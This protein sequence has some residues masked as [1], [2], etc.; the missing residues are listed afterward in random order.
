VIRH[1]AAFGTIQ[2][3]S[4]A[5]KALIDHRQQQVASDMSN[6]SLQPLPTPEA[7]D[8]ATI[9][10]L[11]ARWEQA[12]NSHDAASLAGLVDDDID[13]VTVSGRWL[14]GRREFYDWHRFIHETHLSASSWCNRAWRARQLAATF[15]LVHLE[16]TIDNESGPD[17]TLPTSRSGIFSWIVVCR[18]RCAQILAG[19]N[20]NLAAAA[21][22]RLWRAPIHPE[23]D[24]A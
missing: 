19:H 10:A 3:L 18:D 21:S 5:G 16:W 13:F 4:N 9:N 11:A 12:W 24:V 17:R 6:N 14:Q 2:H 7:V 23:G 20:T 15:S 1:H 22:H 8:A